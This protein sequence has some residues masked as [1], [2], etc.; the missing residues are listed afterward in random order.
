MDF[1]AIRED[2]ILGIYELMFY[3]N[4]IRVISYAQFYQ[5]PTENQR[6]HASVVQC[7]VCYFLRTLKFIALFFF[8]LNGELHVMKHV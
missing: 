5:T 1:I 2:P 4:V 6:R 3:R 7:Y 8:A